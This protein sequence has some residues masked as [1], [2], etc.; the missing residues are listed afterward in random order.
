MVALENGPYNLLSLDGGGI[1]GVSELVILHRIMKRIQEKEQLAELPKPCEYFHLIGGT[2]T[3]GLVALL[4]GRLRLSTQDALDAYD[5]LAKS[6]FSRRNM[7]FSLSSRFGEEPL[8]QAMRDLVQRMG[9]NE[10]MKDPAGDSQHHRMGRSFVCALP[11]QNQRAPKRIRGYLADDDWDQDIKI[12][13]A[14]RATT[15]APSYF[16]PMIVKSGTRLEELIDAAMGFNN[17]TSEVLNEAMQVLD[18]S[19]KLGCV[20]SLGTGTREK[21]LKGSFTRAVQ[22]VKLMKNVTTDSDRVEDEVQK[23]FRDI[24]STYFRFTVPNAA[25]KVGMTKYK[26]I[27]E[28]KVMTE[29]YLDSVTARQDIERV[30]EILCK[31]KSQGWVLGNLFPNE[32]YTRVDKHRANTGGTATRCFTGREEILEKLSLFFDKRENNPMPRRQ[33]LLYGMG[34]VGKTQ[35][36]LKFKQ[37]MEAEERFQH[38]FFVDATDEATIEE[39]YMRISAEQGFQANDISRVLHWMATTKDEWLL[40]LD[41]CPDEDFT[42]YLPSSDR[43]NVLYTS[44]RSVMKLTL[45]DTDT[46]EVEVM[47]ETEAVDLLL[48]VSHQPLASQELR[49]SALPIVKELGFLPLAIEQAGAS[50]SMMRYSLNE[51]LPVLVKQKTQMLSSGSL[52][53]DAPVQEKAV[54][55]TFD[56]SYEDLRSL[57]K[58]K[59]GAIRAEIAEMAIKILNSICFYHNEH[60]VEDIFSQAAEM[61]WGRPPECTKLGVGK[62]RLDSLVEADE[63][64]E[65]IFLGY[66][67]AVALLESL[68]LVRR[69]ERTR[70][71][72]MHVLVHSW[73][74]D[75]MNEA[76]RTGYSIPAR[77]LLFTSIGCL[78]NEKWYHGF[79]RRVY[80]HVLACQRNVKSREDTRTEIHHHVAFARLLETISLE[81]AEKEWRKVLSECTVEVTGD[82]EAHWVP[83]NYLMEVCASLGKFREAE[84]IAATVWKQR[85]DKYGRGH[86]KT[87]SSIARLTDLYIKMGNYTKAR[88]W[89]R[90]GIAL[91]K[92]N[93]SE[94]EMERAQILKERIMVID[95]QLRFTSHL[96]H[97]AALLPSKPFED[98][99]DLAEH[100]A[101]IEND[102][103]PTP[104]QDIADQLVNFWNDYDRDLGYFGPYSRNAMWC[105]K[106]LALEYISLNKITCGKIIAE[107]GAARCGKYY[108]ENH[109]ETLYFKSQIGLAWAHEGR[110]QDGLA[111]QKECFEK[112]IVTTGRH[113]EHTHLIE[114]HLK[115]CETICMNEE[116]RK[117]LALKIQAR[118]PREK[119]GDYLDDEDIYTNECNVLLC[120]QT[121]HRELR[122]RLKTEPDA[123]DGLLEVFGGLDLVWD[124]PGNSQQSLQDPSKERPEGDA[125]GSET[126]GKRKGEE[127][128]GPAPSSGPP[129]GAP[130]NSKEGKQEGAPIIRR[131]E[132][133]ASENKTKTKKG[134]KQDSGISIVHTQGERR[135]TKSK[136]DRKGKQPEVII[137]LN[138]VKYIGAD[139]VNSNSLVH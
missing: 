87:I 130:S 44:R 6:I 119:W 93:G 28:L 137:N 71:L 122:E 17:P 63:D 66:R 57:S 114:G 115:S 26:K 135:S 3:G 85:H 89:C 100:Q 120:G 68:S 94:L 60:I 126:E 138:N 107:E 98:E 51:Y 72:S 91:C 38:I 33:F 53:S 136:Q 4:V 111:L 18:P 77:T 113:S 95:H 110:V 102:R 92:Q 14:A 1:R 129:L 35:I 48:K 133:P 43:G 116:R 74:R 30:A 22:A 131:K 11:A 58:L 84:V 80:P 61:R 104:P 15:A 90:I 64:G 79:R 16:K 31:R 128:S 65:W 39:C 37:L 19:C 47:G 21:H 29:D 32:K 20:V 36:A 105:L 134:R 99:S 23:I 75:R 97:D 13:E 86:S 70:S 25:A 59:K 34:G 101:V 56:V 27:G 127:G 52:Y 10:L 112:S 81:H 50:I 78:S 103:Q 125:T 96:L 108:G 121:G 117:Q 45:P 83:M 55:A 109:H 69:D 67:E 9:A 41:N 106:Q 42:R 139:A 118:I 76:E 49:A 7:R 2:S 132:G 73:A 124:G 12:W 24:P 8:A 88:R 5:S 46:L 82:D 40:I 54:Y 123:P 62:Y